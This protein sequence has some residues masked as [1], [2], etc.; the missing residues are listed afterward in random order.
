[1]NTSPTFKVLFVF[2]LFFP[3]HL[4]LAQD[5]I[6]KQNGDEIPC[7]VVELDPPKVKYRPSD[8]SDGP[9]RVLPYSEVFMIKYDNGTKEILSTP[10]NAI[11]TNA[12]KSTIEERFPRR[13]WAFGVNMMAFGQS[14]VILGL[15]LSGLYTF[16][17][18][19]FRLQ[20]DIGGGVS[21]TSLDYGVASTFS[22]QYAFFMGGN[23]VE[24]SPE[25]GIST[26]YTHGYVGPAA[27][28]L[29]TAFDF[30]L[31]DAFSL[32]LHPRGRFSGN[33]AGFEI[34]I[35]LRFWFGPNR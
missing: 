15:N 24:I 20:L 12:S 17:P 27:V 35:G 33:P 18:V 10:E 23:S 9:I 28:V 22:L 19:P 8:H 1:M 31:K 5:L 21:P 14:D 7:K 2:I 6:V 29:G 13:P 32:H 16:T 30:R 4:L 11:T 34:H 26:M 3:I 25:L